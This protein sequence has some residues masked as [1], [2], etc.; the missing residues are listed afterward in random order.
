V[1]VLRVAVVVL[2]ALGLLIALRP[3]VTILDVMN[4]SSFT[5][6]AVPATAVIGGLYWRR[7][8]VL[9]G[10]ALVFM[11]YFNV[12]RVP[13]IQ[14]VVPSVEAAEA[15][16]AAVS[17]AAPS[18]RGNPGIEAPIGRRTWLLAL[19]FAVLVLLAND[20]WVWGRAPVLVLGLPLWAWY[21]VGLC[22]LLSLGFLLVPG[23]RGGA[24]SQEMPGQ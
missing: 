12:L 13:G 23:R 8:S 22:V 3:P 20:F 10:E 1:G 6:L 19:P 24:Q 18:R 9:V 11:F 4:R 21:S 7:A 5:G 2:G 15:V 14:P 16:F 17:L